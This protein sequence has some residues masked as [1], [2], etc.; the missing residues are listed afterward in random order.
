MRSLEPEPTLCSN[1]FAAIM[2]N[3][4]ELDASDPG[5][6]LDAAAAPPLFDLME[7]I[8]DIRFLDNGL[9]KTDKGGL[10]T[11]T[12]LWTLSLIL[13]YWAIS[14]F[15][16]A[17]LYVN[18]NSFLYLFPFHLIWIFFWQ[19]VWILIRPNKMSHLIWSHIA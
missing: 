3:A 6:D 15:Y 5:F 8:I 7:P 13:I 18:S 2:E 9:V 11:W 19:K 1:P 14:M 10:R 4:G 16:I 17:C 12:G